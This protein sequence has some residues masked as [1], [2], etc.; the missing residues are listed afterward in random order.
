MG[1]HNVVALWKLIDL[2]RSG[3]ITLDNW[4]PVAFRNLM[5]FRDICL[6]QY[7]SLQLAFNYGM[8][9]KGSRTVNLAELQ[10]FCHDMEFTGNVHELFAALDERQSGFITVDELDFLSRWEGQ[11]FKPPRSLGLQ[12]LQIC[13]HQ[14]RCQ[15]EK[16]V[17]ER[18][19][20]HQER[21]SIAWAR[22]QR[23]SFLEIQKQLPSQAQFDVE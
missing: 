14:R 16:L 4:D 13:Q 9:V 11:R 17:R 20:S 8:D 1:F 5:E 7:G 19:R 6:R 12:R 3:F 18:C 21:A 15:K 22:E 2:N 10:R 23:Q